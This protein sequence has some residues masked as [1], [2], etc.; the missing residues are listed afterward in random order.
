MKQQKT[1]KFITRFLFVFFVHLIIKIGDQ[2]FTGFFDISERGLIFSAWFISYWL[3][4]W[5]LAD[6]FNQKILA[7]QEVTLKNKKSYIYILFTFHF[8][9]GLIASFIANITY[10]YMDV[11]FF[12]NGD[13]WSTIPI[14]NPEFTFSMLSIYMMVFTFDTFYHSN[15]RQKEDQLKMEQLEK[16]STMAQYLNL[17]S[18][19]EPHF[20]FNSLSVLSSLIY[21]NADLA[22]EF[23]LRLSRILRYVIEKNKFL[24]V[25]LKDEIDFV[26]DYI[27]LA[28]TRFEE[29]IICDTNLDKKV[30][31][32]G[33]IPPTALQTLVE[34]AIKHN[35]FT[36]D[37]PLKITVSNNDK[38][39]IVKNNL[40]LRNDITN[41]TKQGLDNLKAR[42]FHFTDVP[43]E[44]IQTS[45]EFIV[46]LPLLTKEHYE[47]FNI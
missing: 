41:S 45:D 43:V 8:F 27:F 36:K 30:I 46:S 14:I 28:Q 11:H 2:S 1:N 37:K 4:I 26:N 12:N 5:Y 35:K 39:L 9:F 20:L 25:P 19:I 6:F 15:I 16:E 22:S 21:S 38:S 40:Q 33:F 29:K 31:N 34:N 47:R 32:T 44:I 42:Y 17:K 3:I 18:Q 10:R 7:K 24:L 23:V 13:V